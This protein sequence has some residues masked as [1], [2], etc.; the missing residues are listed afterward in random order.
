[1]RRGLRHRVGRATSWLRPLPDTLIVGTMRGGTT[2]LF[3]YLSEHPLVARGAVKEVKYF[4]PEASYARGPGWYRAHF[5]TRVALSA[6]AARGGGRPRVLDARP[7]YLYRTVSHARIAALLPGARLIALLRDPVAR[8]HSHFGLVRDRYA[9]AE[10]FER[11]VE[12]GL[13]RRAGGASAD[14]VPGP[15]RGTAGSPQQLDPDD[16]PERHDRRSGEPRL[17]D[18][19]R[20]GRV[21]EL[22]RVHDDSRRAARE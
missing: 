9:Y 3:T 8:A 16:D 4:W 20:G 11:S 6:R 10:T 21:D 1:M 22:S 12:I 15:E 17:D 7:A 5:P 19:G 2:S 14:S 13:G 18:G